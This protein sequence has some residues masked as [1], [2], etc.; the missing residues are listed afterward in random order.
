MIALV[1]LWNYHF[2]LTQSFCVTF[3]VHFVI[4]DYSSHPRCDAFVAQLDFWLTFA[5]S[6]IVSSLLSATLQPE[7]ARK[8]HRYKYGVHSDSLVCCIS[9]E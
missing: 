5:D 2:V 3:F 7:R 1:D 9:L 4:L 8:C 6:S